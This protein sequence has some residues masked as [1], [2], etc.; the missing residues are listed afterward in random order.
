M[1]YFII[2]HTLLA[3]WLKYPTILDKSPPTIVEWGEIIY[4]TTIVLAQVLFTARAIDLLRGLFA[5]LEVPVQLSFGTFVI[6]IIF[7][8]YLAIPAFAVEEK[9]TNI[10]EFLYFVVDESMALLTILLL[11]QAERTIFGTGVFDNPFNNDF[12]QDNSYGNGLIAMGVAS[13]LYIIPLLIYFALRQGIF[14]VE[15][16]ICFVRNLVGWE[17]LLLTGS[18]YFLL[19]LPVEYQAW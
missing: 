1:I 6:Y 13:F 18:R 7:A 19:L 4:S 14:T 2:L 8:T 9:L 5:Y 10:P 16:T 15:F 12:V 17:G 3:H 11:P